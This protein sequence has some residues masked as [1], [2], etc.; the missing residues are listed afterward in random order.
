MYLGNKPRGKR[1]KPMVKNFSSGGARLN[2]TGFDESA[3]QNI[4][5]SNLGSNL[6]AL[7]RSSCPKGRERRGRKRERGVAVR[8]SCSRGRERRGERER[9][10]EREGEVWPS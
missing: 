6:F 4:T 3:S 7:I 9:E 5:C 1:G 10:R 8:N 2:L